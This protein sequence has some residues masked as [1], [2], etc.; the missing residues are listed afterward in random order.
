MSYP[1]GYPCQQ[2]T[3][4]VVPAQNHDPCEDAEKIK[5]AMESWLI[6]DVAITR[7]LSMRSRE[8]RLHIAAVFKVLYGK[9][10]IER[11]EKKLHFNFKKSVLAMMTPLPDFHAKEL[12]DAITGTGKDDDALLEVLCSMSNQEIL[13]IRQAYH[14]MYHS[15][16][17]ND[18]KGDTS[19]IFKRLMVSLCRACR[20]ENTPANQ[21][22]A[23]EDAQWL[24]DV[25]EK[26]ILGTDESTFIRV[27]SHRSFTQLQL[28]FMEYERISGHDIEEAIKSQFSGISQLGFLAIVHNIKNQPLFFAKMLNKSMKGLGTRN[29]QLIRLMTTRCEI[30]MEDIAREYE[31]KYGESLID[32]IKGDC[33]GDYRRFMVALIRGPS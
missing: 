24:Y 10:L 8:Q 4:T 31:A 25:G 7:V 15:N 6:N 21:E 27:F 2:G 16:L 14:A 12:H 17:E 13:A 18:I 5:V 9:D 32:A 22:E 1:S 30:D 3:P 11:F 26:R 28:I 29:R 20:D 33:S 19:G 23:T